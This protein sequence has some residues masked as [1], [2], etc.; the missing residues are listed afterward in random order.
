MD[1]DLLI[2]GLGPVGAV[3]ANL[4]GSWGLKTLAVDKM[5]DI[6]D[7]PRAFGLDHEVM[8]VFGNIGI[9]GRIADAVLPYRTSEYHTTGGAVVKRIA[10]ASAPYPLG[11]ASNYVFSQPAVE[12]ALRGNV[13]SFP[14]VSLELG[15]EVLSLTQ[16]GGVATALLRDR[17][18]A[19]RSV[20]ARYVLACDGGTSPLRTSLGLEMEDMAFDEPW[21]VVDVLV[22]PEALGR[23]PDTNVQFCETAR[24]SSYIV[25]PGG[26]RRWEFTINEGETP[27]SI[28]QPDA[29]RRLLSRWLEP[30]EYEIW[31]AS[32]YRF[33]ALVLKTWRQDGLFFLGDAAHMTPPFMA[34]GMCQG[35]RD[36]ANLVWKL[37]MVNQGLAPDSLLDTYQEER[38]PH[39]R[40]TTMVTKE[41]GQVICERDPARAAA[42][43]RR[44]LEEMAQAAGPTIR[45]SLIPG[46]TS[47]LLAPADPLGVR[48]TLFPQPFVENPLG[49]AGLLDEFTGAAFR[50]VAAPG[51]ELEA[52]RQEIGRYAGFPLVLARLAAQ[53]QD[54]LGPHDF[55][56]RDGVLGAWFDRHGCQLALVRPDHYVFGGAASLAGGLALLHALRQMLST[57]ENGATLAA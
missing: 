3:A 36:A 12:G 38:L 1:F 25:G 48:G 21:M 34:Q 7:K 53:D 44:M 29:I 35:I 52:L 42:R 18:D 11:W 5:L 54:A 13:Q 57:R 26:H 8:R 4:A 49:L 16:Q 32:A 14:S 9:A 24:P 39:V 15:T 10:P 19:E 28:Q 41:L 43:D 6:Y 17:S 46:L 30:Q 50:L 40:Q 37:A 23:L 45:Q 55:R 47:G 31:R 33:H 56:E 22:K 2:V 27:A 51:T 20:S